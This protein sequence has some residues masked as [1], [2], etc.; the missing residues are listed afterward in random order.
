VREKL[1]ELEIPHLMRSVGRGSP[2]RQE[3]MDRRGIF[4]APYIED[5]NTG[6]ALFES[7]AIVKYLE[8]TYASA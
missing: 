2:K 8:D 1:V 3:L 4:Q 7:A 6:V 5:P